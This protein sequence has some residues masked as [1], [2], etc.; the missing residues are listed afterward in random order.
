[1]TAYMSGDGALAQVLVGRFGA[2]LALIG[3]SAARRGG[4]IIAASDQLDGQAVAYAFSKH[5]LIG[6]EIFQASA[7]LSDSPV[8]RGEAVALDFMRWL[9]IAA[10][11]ALAA[12]RILTAGG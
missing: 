11:V 9:L 4:T 12:S 5:A 1:M 10:I 6:E 7:Y 8:R 2:E 3:E